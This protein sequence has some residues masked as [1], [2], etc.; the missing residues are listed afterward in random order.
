M[1]KTNNNKN[2][3]SRKLHYF[4][5]SGTVLSALPV[6][7]H[8]PS[9][10]HPESTITFPILQTI[11][12]RM[13]SLRHFP[14]VNTVNKRRRQYFSSAA[15]APKSNLNT[16]LLAIAPHVDHLGTCRNPSPHFCRDCIL[17]KV[18]MIKAIGCK[19]LILMFVEQISR[20]LTNSIRS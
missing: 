12:L 8:Q 18:F 14:E 1:A 10:P 9:H 2:I 3:N 11:K 15:R 20:M 4:Y 13:K 6:F 17:T 16:V 19:M 7:T 5:T